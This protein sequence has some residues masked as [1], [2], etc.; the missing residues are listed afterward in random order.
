MCT[1][2]AYCIHSIFTDVKG[3]FRWKWQTISG[4]TWRITSSF[5]I[6]FFVCLFVWSTKTV[7]PIIF[8]LRNRRIIFMFSEIRH[9][10]WLQ[11]L[12]E[13]WVF[14]RKIERQN[15]DYDEKKS[16]F[17]CVFWWLRRNLSE[18][19][20]FESCKWRFFWTD[21]KFIE[22]LANKQIIRSNTSSILPISLCTVFVVVFSF[23]NSQCGG[24]FIMMRCRFDYCHSDIPFYM[25]FV[26]KRDKKAQNMQMTW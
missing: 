25:V 6:V 13:K 11:R 15:N 21:E 17:N 22:Y 24:V 4:F 16:R 9:I 19:C 26:L 20:N 3:M 14:S 18:N 10:S 1:K 12:T 2:Y 8:G 7:N 5:G 23:V